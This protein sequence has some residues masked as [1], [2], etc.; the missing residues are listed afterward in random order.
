MLPA[1]LE[2]NFINPDYRG[3]QPRGLPA[4]AASGAMGARGAMGAMGCRRSGVPKREARV[5][6]R[7]STARDILAE[8]DA[9]RRQ[10]GHRHARARA[11]RRVSI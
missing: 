3:A 6:R 8:I 5:R 4:A 2:S 7:I 11:G 1:H 9:R 10:R